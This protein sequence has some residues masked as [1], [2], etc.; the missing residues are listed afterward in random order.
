MFS[1]LK[2]W[3]QLFS[4]RF[5]DTSRDF[6][7][8]S[9]MIRTS[10]NFEETVVSPIG[11]PRISDE[12]V[13]YAIL[14]APTK[15]TNCMTT[16]S[17]SVHVLVDT[18][19]KKKQIFVLILERVRFVIVCT[20]IQTI[21][22]VQQIFVNGECTF[23]W[24]IF[25]NFLA[26]VINITWNGVWRLAE[27]FIFFVRFLVVFFAFLNTF[28]CFAAF[29]ITWSSCTVHMMLAW[30]DFIWTT[31]LIRTVWTTGDN[32]FAHPIAPCSTRET[33]VWYEK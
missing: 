20:K 6:A 27:M 19:R 12:P 21:F 4:G 24:T 17:F 18:Y 28:R 9:T 7:F 1:I 11:V 5:R 16:K 33:T 15:N 8:N 26:N 14:G 13:I 2:F 30:L 23:D 22:V 31:T 10:K 3:V 29:T 25:E 32:A